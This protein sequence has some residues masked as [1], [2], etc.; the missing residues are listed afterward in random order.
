MGNY[1]DYLNKNFSYADLTKERKIQLRK[2][3]KLRGNREIFTYASALT[4][5]APTS[6]D[7]DDLLPISDQLGNLKGDKIDIILETPG[8]SAEVAEDIVK[9]IRSRFNEVGIIIPGYAKSAGTIMAMAGDEIL[10][11]PISALGPIDAQIIH[12]GKRFSAHAFLQGLKKIKEEVEKQGGL[13]RAYIPTLQN[14]SPGD[15]Q[16]CENLLSFSETLVSEWLKN[17]KFKFWD[18]HSSTGKKVTEEEKVKRADKIAEILCD[19]GKWLTHGRSIK[20]EDLEKMGLKVQDYSKNPEL[21]GAISRYYTLIKMT[22]ESTSIYKI[23]ETPESQ[24]FRFSQP[25]T[26]QLPVAGKKPITKAIID[27]ACPSC[28]NVT[29]IQANF[30]K[31][32][33]IEKG[34]TSFPKNGMFICP[35]CKNTNNINAIR[36]QIEMQ[37]KQK[38]V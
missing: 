34:A 30:K 37:T 15:I 16:N 12:G 7:Y 1:S 2:I 25:Q 22:F 11:E 19:H 17:Y 6:I 18:T 35:S 20:I 9:F 23:F 38:I 28:K 5:Q 32:L 33:P 31:N 36:Q 27:F 13:N 24:I 3:S 14:I 10:L 8:G 4:K 29:K 21:H 26:Q